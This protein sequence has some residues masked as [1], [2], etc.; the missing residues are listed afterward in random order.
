MFWITNSGHKTQDQLIMPIT[1]ID[2][3]T[4]NAAFRK[5]NIVRDTCI[6]TKI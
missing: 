1:N 3:R 2:P 5:I 4:C 6:L